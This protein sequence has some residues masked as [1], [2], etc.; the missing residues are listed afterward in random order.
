MEQLVQRAREGDE[1]A[2]NQV[3]EALRPF[4]KQVASACA[5]RPLVWGNDDELSIALIA[6]NE[7]IST[8]R[9]EAGRQFQNHA[10]QVIARRLVDHFRREGRHAALSLDRATDQTASALEA[11]AA[12]ARYQEREEEQQRHA[13]I[14]EYDRL[15]QEYGLS[16]KDLKEHCPKHSDTRQRLLQAT[17]A[18]CR[19]A[20]WVGYV[21]RTKQLPLKELEQAT[22][23]SRKVLETGRRYVLALA[24]LMLHPELEHIRSFAGLT[25]QEGGRDG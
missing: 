5:R 8:Y 20:D 9:A 22:G 16:L 15:L 19:N 17:R 25:T 18:L 23:T 14:M 2:R 21:R 13:E 12:W 24:L 7:A 11:G 10:R 1:T 3:L 4:V 6:L